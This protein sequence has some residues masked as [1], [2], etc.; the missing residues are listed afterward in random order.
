VEE[1][2]AELETLDAR[3]KGI[4]AQ[5]EIADEPPPFLHRELTGLYCQKVPTLVR[6]LEVS[7]TR[8][9]ATEAPPWLIG[10]DGCGGGM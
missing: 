9:P 5:L 7:G 2:Q 6:A 1:G 8:T 4:Q 3:R 10:A